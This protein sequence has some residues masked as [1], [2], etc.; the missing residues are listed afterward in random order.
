MIFHHRKSS[1][2]TFSMWVWATFILMP[3]VMSETQGSWSWCMRQLCVEVLLADSQ[4]LPVWWWLARKDRW[5]KVSL[6]A[7]CEKPKFSPICSLVIFLNC[8]MPL[9][10]SS[11]TQLCPIHCD[12]MDCSMPGFPVHHQLPKPTQTHTHHV[13]DAIQ[14]SHPLLSPSSLAFNLSQHHGLFK[15]VSS[16]HQVTK[17]V[18]FQLHHQSF[19]RIFRTDLL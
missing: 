15:W 12:S 8:Y 3:P 16:S 7:D 11:V 14:P 6:Q 17:V 10:L 19:Q 18:G 5:E 2:P 4:G 13:G 1:W 9:Q